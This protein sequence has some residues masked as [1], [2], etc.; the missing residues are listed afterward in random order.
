MGSVGRVALSSSTV[1]QMMTKAVSGPHGQYISTVTD[2]AWLRTT[3]FLSQ[4]S[5]RD[6]ILCSE[7]CCGDMQ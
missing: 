6:G 5:R 1:T 4:I 3:P 2:K 7:C